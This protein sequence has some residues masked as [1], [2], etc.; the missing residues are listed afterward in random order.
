MLYADISGFTALSRRLSEV[1]GLRRGVDVLSDVLEEVYEGVVTAIHQ[2]AGA[3]IGFSGDAVSCWFDDT[4]DGLAD[5][6]STARTVTGRRPEP[7][8][9]TGPW[10]PR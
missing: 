9:P 3:V 8:A 1:F 6:G 7:A 2:R 5:S 4:P 10:P